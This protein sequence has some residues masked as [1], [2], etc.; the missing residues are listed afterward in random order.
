MRQQ[1]NAKLILIGCGGC[2]GVVVVA[3]VVVTYLGWNIFSDQAKDALAANPVVQEHLGEV[4]SISVDLEATGDAEGS[5]VFVFRVEGSRA[6]GTVTAEFITVDD[7][8]EELGSG[9]LVLDSGETYPLL[10]E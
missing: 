3:A 7:A 9:T 10:P 6:S 2:L 8:T 4:H 1:G 5:D